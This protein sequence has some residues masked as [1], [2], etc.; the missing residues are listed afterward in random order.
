[1]NNL[2][3]KSIEVPV[4]CSFFLR[5]EWDPYWVNLCCWWACVLSRSN[6]RLLVLLLGSVEIG[7][8][9]LYRVYEIIIFLCSFYFTFQSPSTLVV[10][11]WYLNNT[12]KIYSHWRVDWF[13]VQSGGG[14]HH[15][16]HH[17]DGLDWVTNQSVLARGQTDTPP[18]TGRVSRKRTSSTACQDSLIDQSKVGPEVILLILMLATITKIMKFVSPISKTF[19]RVFKQTGSVFYSTRKSVCTINF[20]SEVV[21]FL[22]FKKL[23][24]I[25]YHEGY[26]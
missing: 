6:K 12:F 8:F 3:F 10:G 21:Y 2:N 25:R 4:V 1:M 19:V 7:E 23:F 13:S 11:S 9:H 18:T 24:D 16:H 5:C 20:M 22:S 15:H 14:T 26:Q 17:Q